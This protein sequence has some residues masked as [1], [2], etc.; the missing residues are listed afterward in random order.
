MVRNFKEYIKERGLTQTHIAQQM[1]VSRQSFNC[2]VRGEKNP[3]ARTLVRIAKAMT[4]LGAP[5]TAKDI[6]PYFGAYND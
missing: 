4:D 2:W 1:G 6:V 3:T 5:T